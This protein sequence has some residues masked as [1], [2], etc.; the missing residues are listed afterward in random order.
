[1]FWLELAWLGGGATRS[2]LPHFDQSQGLPL[3]GKVA[4]ALSLTL[5]VQSQV[6]VAD[7]GYENRLA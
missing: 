5:L 3:E 1:M 6:D 4:A 7:C 2:A